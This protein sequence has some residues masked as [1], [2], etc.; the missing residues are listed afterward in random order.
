MQ[1]NKLL[2]LPMLILLKLFLL[3]LLQLDNPNGVLYFEIGDIIL[4]ICHF[5]LQVTTS[6]LNQLLL[7]AGIVDFSRKLFYMRIMTSLIDTSKD[8]TSEIYSH[9][10]PTLNV[11]DH[12]N[13][14]RWHKMRAVT[15]DIGKKYTY[16][17]FVYSSVLLVFFCLM[18]AYLLL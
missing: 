5:C 16:R 6:F 10:M 13:I 7:F 12:N 3:F 1:I 9:Y 14:R 4:Y 17:I 2:I 15:L 11:L 8:H 18:A